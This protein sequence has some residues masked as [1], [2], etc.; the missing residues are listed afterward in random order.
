MFGVGFYS[1]SANVTRQTRTNLYVDM[2]KDNDKTQAALYGT[3]GLSLY[4][5]VVLGVPSRGMIVFQQA[6]I[7]GDW[8][9]SVHGNDVYRISPS[10]VITNVGGMAPGSRTGP[11]SMAWNGTQILICDGFLA[12]LYVPGTG[13]F[14]TPAGLVGLS[15]QTCCFLNGYFLV[16]AAGT[17]R[18]YWSTLYDGTLW[19]ALDFAT[20][21][22][23]PDN[24]L[25]VT[26][27]H[28]ELY[29]LGVSTSEVWVPSGDASVW[30][31]LGGAAVE[32]GIV[33]PATLAKSGDTGIMFLA[34][35]R[36]GETQVIRMEGYQAQPITDS[37]VAHAINATS[38]LS[39]TTGFSYMVDAHPFYQLNLPTMSFLYDGASELWS[40]VSSGLVGGRHLAQYRAAL[41][42]QPYVSDYQSGNIYLLDKNNYTDNDATIIREVVGRHIFNDYERRS[43][44][45]LQVDFEE[46]TGLT[47]GQGVNPQVM[48]QISKDGGHTWGNEL[49]TTIGAMGAYATR[50]IW[51]RLGIARDWVFKLR[52]SDPVKVVI[53]GAGI[54]IQ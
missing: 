18:F 9:V 52:I 40:Y 23:S 3:P 34:A 21:E 5:T 1:K 8:I 44:L 4:L 27:D 19:D 53:I 7:P 39:A 29:L 6:A 47:T 33:G 12:K 42:Q 51:R 36:L 13:A 32:W 16:N 43:V 38:D 31:R 50:A 22:S 25:A 14:T 35:N 48:L 49:W 46:G 15:P 10:L 37:E 30:V 41:G 24:V 54:K 45:E 2:Q 17:G 28:G 11:V 26:A 20:A